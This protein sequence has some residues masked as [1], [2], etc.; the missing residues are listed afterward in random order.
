MAS[1]ISGQMGVELLFQVREAYRILRVPKER[2]EKRRFVGTYLRLPVHPLIDK[3]I[4]CT[5]HAVFFF[6]GDGDDALPRADP[7]AWQ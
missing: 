5:E 1:L 2:V 6:F 4:A 3:V 7:P